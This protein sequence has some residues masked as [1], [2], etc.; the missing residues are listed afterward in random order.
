[1]KI[2][3]FNFKPFML[4][5][6]ASIEEIKRNYPMDNVVVCEEKA[7]IMKELPDTDILVS[8]FF[9]TEML[10]AAPNLK[11]VQGLSAGVD[12][13][14]L[15]EMGRRG[16]LLTNGRGVHKIHMTEYAIMAMV[17]MARNFHVMSKNQFLKCYDRDVHQGQIHGATVG[18]VGLGSIGMEI[19][20]VAK[21]MGMKVLAVKNALGELPD[22]IDRAYGKEDMKK[23]FEESDYVINL[24]PATQATHKLI[25]KTYFDAMKKTGVFINMG[26]GTTVNEEDLIKALQT[27]AIKGLV[28]DVYY[29][30]PLPE[31][32]P[33]WDLD[34]VIMTP[35]ICGENDRYMEKAY[36]I[37][38]ENLKVFHE[39]KGE[40]VNKVDLSRGY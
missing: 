13:M 34:N 10:E 11:W 30:E 15:Q 9:T 1:M 39:G 40:M 16:I 20:R 2:L 18:I 33:L 31:D 38:K 37:L 36:V 14:P 12:K 22:F 17:M 28:T 5:P 29:R 24:L 35:H 26:R 19:A 3:I 8:F 21:F 4:M 32:S 27:G 25:D 6:E 23:V 7:V